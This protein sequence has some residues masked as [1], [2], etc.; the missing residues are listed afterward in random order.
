M[1]KKMWKRSDF[2]LASGEFLH[3]RLFKSFDT[4]EFGNII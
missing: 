3:K 4:G 2:F 1:F